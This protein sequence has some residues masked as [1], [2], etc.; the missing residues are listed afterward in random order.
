MSKINIQS[1]VFLLSQNQSK[2]FFV[3][4]F[5]KFD[6]ISNDIKGGKKKRSK[7]PTPF[8]WSKTWEVDHTRTLVLSLSL[9]LS[10][11]HTHA[12][13]HTHKHAHEHIHA[14]TYTHTQTRTRTHTRTHKHAHE[15]VHTHKHV[16]YCQKTKL[17]N[18]IIGTLLTAIGSKKRGLELYFPQVPL[19]PEF[20]HTHTL[21]RACPR[22]GRCVCTRGGGC[23]WGKCNYQTSYFF[24]PIRL[25]SPF[26]SRF[27]EY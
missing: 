22:V 20:T 25:I 2:N 26:P 3:S 23:T 16:L 12:Q 21:P 11:T 4:E 19:T 7:K 10:L 18:L 24:V 17:L 5:I 13:R 8:F 14:H 27:G 9:S 15:H 6:L 1:S